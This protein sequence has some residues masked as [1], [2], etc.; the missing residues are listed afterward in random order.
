MFYGCRFAVIGSTGNHY[1]VT[2]SN[3]QHTCNCIDFKIRKRMC[4]HIRLVLSSLGV[5]DSPGDWKEVA[6]VLPQ[7]CTLRLNR[8]FISN[9]CFV[10]RLWKNKLQKCLKQHD[11]HDGLV[12]NTLDQWDWGREDTAMGN[13]YLE[14]DQSHQQTHNLGLCAGIL[15][16]CLFVVFLQ[17]YAGCDAAI[18]HTDSCLKPM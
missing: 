18:W 1:M 10:W 16:I 12:R 13:G 3:A 9:P 8:C 14:W 15:I 5:E 6:I 17:K 7:D 2:L 11:Y 4:K